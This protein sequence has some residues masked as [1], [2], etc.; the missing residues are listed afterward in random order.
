[1]FLTAVRKGCIL[2]SKSLGSRQISWA[3]SWSS[4]WPLCWNFA[5][6]QR[7]SGEESVSIHLNCFPTLLCPKMTPTWSRLSF[8]P[9]VLAHR[10]HY[11]FI[12]FILSFLIFCFPHSLIFPNRSASIQI[13]TT[14]CLQLQKNEQAGE[15]KNTIQD[16]VLGKI[17]LSSPAYFQK[18]LLLQMIGK[19]LD[20]HSAEME[21]LHEAE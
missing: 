2:K 21:F 13:S 5:L 3:C 12:N 10:L 7:C 15:E 1:M 20:Y 6:P 11:R 16:I 9:K 14:N 17:W 4:A 18:Q 19:T 8:S